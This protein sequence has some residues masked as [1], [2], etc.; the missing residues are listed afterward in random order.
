MRQIELKERIFNRLEGLIYIQGVSGFE[1]NVV[2]RIYSQLEDHLLDLEIDPL[3]NLY[4]K[5]EGKREGPTLMVAAHVDQIG[6]VV[7]YIDDDGFLRFE[8]VGGLIPRQLPG[9]K[10]S[11]QGHFGVIGCKS[12]HYQS[13]EEAL[14]GRGEDLY[15]DVGARSFEEVLE[16]GIDIGSPITYLSSIHHFTNRDLICSA[17][18]D[19]RLG[20]ALLIETLLLLDDFPGDL[21]ATFTVQEEIGFRGAMAAVRKKRPDFLLA[22]DTIPAGKTPDLPEEIL[23]TD[24]GKGPVIPVLSGHGDSLLIT[25]ASIR[26]LLVESAREEHLPYQMV[27]AD[28]GNNDAA[29]SQSIGAGIP[30][31]SICIPR[32]YSH[33]P[34]E[35]GHLDDVLASLRILKRFIER[36]DELIDGIREI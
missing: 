28:R 30:S 32:R 21:L 3:G 19:N 22:L 9:R 2:R 18:L 34:V 14:G 17:G 26:Q 29:A 11:V 1:E 4:V 33:S 36:M 23:K 20:C 35:V 7:K 24:I 10:V 6:A 15:I 5:K 25:N 13:K 16:M 12:G 31:A 8:R 27:I